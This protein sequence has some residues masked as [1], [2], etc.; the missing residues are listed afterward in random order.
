MGVHLNKW[1]QEI[2][3]YKTV[4]KEKMVLGG[5]FVGS[6][7]PDGNLLATTEKR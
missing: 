3:Y 6:R 5:T 4:M 7:W 1:K 2:V